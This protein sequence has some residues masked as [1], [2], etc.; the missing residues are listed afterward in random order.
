[1]A[2]LQG[3]GD[4]RAEA[5]SQADLLGGEKEVSGQNMSLGDFTPRV[6]NGI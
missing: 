3:F 5:T 6:Q 1:M 4:V 2:L